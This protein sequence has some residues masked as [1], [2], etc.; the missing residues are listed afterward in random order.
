M[1]VVVIVVVVKLQVELLRGVSESERIVI[2]HSRAISER[3][4]VAM[5]TTHVV[6]VVV[7]NLD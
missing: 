6:V 3:N 5:T 1:N 7:I 4:R 2:V